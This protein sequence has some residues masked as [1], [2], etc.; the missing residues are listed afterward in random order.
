MQTDERTKTDG[1]SLKK[2]FHSLK[3]SAVIK[4]KLDTVTWK[5]FLL[6]S[7]IVRRKILRFFLKTSE[8]F[9]EQKIPLLSV[10]HCFFEFTR[11]LIFERVS[12]R[13]LDYSENIL[14][15]FGIEILP[16]CIELA[17][18]DYNLT[19][20][21]DFVQASLVLTF[22]R[23]IPFFSIENDQLKLYL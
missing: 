21:T 20:Q 6:P 16:A 13:F 17:H 11:S 19:G 18:V 3:I 23:I 8:W 12:R 5:A 1:G 9:L 2:H 7:P 15:H 4:K 10:F 22:T 14:L